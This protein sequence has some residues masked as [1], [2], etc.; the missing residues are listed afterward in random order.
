MLDQIPKSPGRG[1]SVLILAKAFPPV[2]GGVETYSEQVARAYLDAGLNVTVI[3]QGAFDSPGRRRRSFPEGELLIE[4]CGAGGQLTVARKIR[5]AASVL[6]TSGDYD[7]VH[8]TTWRPAAALA[9]LRNVPRTVVT[10]HGREIMYA[11]RW[12]R[13]V[14]RR[15][16]SH[17]VLVVAVSAATKRRAT[18]AIGAPVHNRWIV[19]GNGISFPGLASRAV[20]SRPAKQR[21]QLFTIARLVE[22]KNVHGVLAALA[23]LP[24]EVLTKLEYVIAGDGPMRAELEKAVISHGLN[25]N[26]AFVGRIS[27]DELVE[28]L[29]ASDIF[30]HPQISI[31]GGRDFEGFGLVIADAMSFG[32]AVI[33]GTD[34]GPSDFVVSGESGLLTDGTDIESV[35]AAITELVVDDELR[36]RVSA[37]GREYA[38]A[39]LSWSAHVRAILEELGD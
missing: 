8:A 14:M 16:L 26:V 32:N 6:L 11:P 27:D 29:Q 3:T 12:A 30:V 1:R 33:A 25:E 35:A 21:V 34:G 7:F 13:P 10:V 28:H 24:S 18:A 4:E 20:S 19:A 31:D 9:G 22:R 15:I 36:N 38:L 39:H 37:T 17:A 23:S 5:R 2:P